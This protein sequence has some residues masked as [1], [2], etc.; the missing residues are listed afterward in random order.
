MDAAMQATAAMDE[1]GVAPHA[2][3]P[4]APGPGTAGPLRVLLAERR[5][6]AHSDLSRRLA[7]L[8]HEV[9]ARVTSTQGAV[10]YAG[11]LCPDVVLVSPRNPLNI[12]AVAR[13]MAN[14]GLERLAV[15]APFE[16]HW[17]EARSAAGGSSG[18]S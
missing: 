6:S 2:P 12:G 9:L 7:S 14:F 13:A 16:A 17:R 10:D 5:A 15:V 8:G 11:F 1:N 18:S 4:V 3:S